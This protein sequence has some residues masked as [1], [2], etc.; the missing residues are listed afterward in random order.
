MKTLLIQ[1]KEI[2]MFA[3]IMSATSMFAQDTPDHS[4]DLGAKIND[5]TITQ[6]GTVVVAT[7]DGLVGIKPGKEGTLFNFTDYGRVKPEELKFVPLSPY[8]VVGQ[9]GFGGLQTKSAVIDYHWNY[10]LNGEDKTLTDK[11]RGPKEYDEITSVQTEVVEEGDVPK[12]QDF[13]IE[14]E[15]E[16]LTQEFLETDKLVM[17]VSYN[18]DKAEND[19]L[20]NL[21]SMIRQAE[22]KG[23]T[24]I[25]LSAS[26]ETGAAE[27][28]SN[29][30]F[31][32]DFYLCDEKVLKTV[33][34]SNP[35]VVVLE[36]GTVMQKVHWNDIDDLEFE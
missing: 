11:G 21:G 33:V 13:T 10:T 29:F 34:R 16:D 12:I 28:K 8:V 26:G 7:N 35:G 15:S 2:L 5:M 23:Y 31:D 27:L 19:G 9:T 30:N 3:L 24:V 32:V 17:I 22:S 36:K 18:F 25:G 14:S 20:A 4:Y 6:G 1:I